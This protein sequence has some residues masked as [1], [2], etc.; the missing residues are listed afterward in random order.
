MIPRTLACFLLV[1]SLNTALQSQ[2]K[3]ETPVKATVCQLKSDPAAYEHKLVE[4]TGFVMTGGREDFNLF[5]PACPERPDVKLKDGGETIENITTRL[6]DDARFNQFSNLLGNTVVHA[7]L[8][9]RFFAAKEVQYENGFRRSG[10][11]RLAIERVVSVD[12]HSS[13]AFDYAALAFDDEPETADKTGCGYT[14]LTEMFPTAE[15]VQAQEKADRGEDEWV[16]TDPKRVATSGLAQLLTVDENSIK[17]KLKRRAQGRFVYEWRPKKEG[18]YYVVVVN[19]P[20]LVSFYAKNPN[21]VAW[22]LR[23]VYEAGC[24]ENKAIRRIN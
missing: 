13:K 17:L 18:D 16:F 23:T 20:Y 14:E 1:F 19:R 12:P 21:R 24:G 6:V 2:S 5:D 11:N 9:G 3:S 8:V 15:L 10:R 22:V 7:T 4:V